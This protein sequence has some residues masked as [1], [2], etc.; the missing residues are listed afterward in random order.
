MTPFPDD[1]LALP[2]IPVRILAD[3]AD[4][5]RSALIRGYRT[6][7]IGA[8]EGAAWLD[9]TIADGAVASV[10]ERTTLPA[11]VIPPENAA[12]AHVLLFENLFRDPDRPGDDRGDMACGTF[13]LA[14]ALAQAG[15]R[16]TLIRGALDEATGLDDTGRLDAVLATDPPDLVGITVL[17]ACLPGVAALVRH[18]SQKT[19]AVLAVGGPMVTWTPL[20][21]LAHLPGAHLA[22]RG[23]GEEVLP[24][25]AGLLRG[26]LDTLSDEAILRQD[27]VIL[28]RDGRIVAGKL[29]RPA[30]V[31]VDWT[32]M[33]FEL[34]QDRHLQTG[35]SLETGR[36][37]AHG[38]L[39]CT[40]PGR[41]EHRGRRGAVVADH[42]ERYERRLETLY[43][44]DVPRIARRLQ[45]CDD[46]FTSDPERAADVLAAVAASGLKLSAFQASV[47]DLIDRRSGEVRGELL[48]AI[49]PEMFQ[50]VAAVAPTGPASGRL[51]PHT[52]AFVHLGIESFAGGDL[53]RLGKGY[54]PAD[55]FDVVAALDGRGIVHDVY[56]ILGNRGTT[57]DD[58]V[59]SLT[60][61][62][63]LKIQHPHT[64]FLR[65]PVVPFVVPTYPS[66]LYRAWSRGR[67]RGEDLGEVEVEQTLRLEGIPE[68]DY[69]LVGRE[70]PAD[71][72]AAA[73]CEAW[74]AW[75]E[76]D[77]RYE[78]PLVN[79]RKWLMQRL[80]GVRD[81]D[82]AVR[83]RRAARK[84]S[85]AR[86]RI[87]LGGVARARRNQLRREVSERYWSEAADLGLP[88]EVIPRVRNA[89]EVGDPRLVVI[90][91][92]DCSLRCAYCPADK[93]PGLEMS[94]ET[95]RRSVELLLS[96]DAPRA[97]L[98]FFGGEALL[99]R[100][101]VL[102]TLD[103]GLELATELGKEIG[104]ILSTNGLSLDPDL[105]S[106]LAHLPVKVEISLDGGPRVHNLH[107]RAADPAIDSY[108]LVTRHLDDLFDSGI[109]H[110]VIMVVTPETVADLCD[111]FAHVAALGFRRIQVNHGLAV[112]WSKEHK[113]AL[114][115]QLRAIE[116]RFFTGAL[117]DAGVEWIDL[118]SFRDP[119]LLNGETT[120]DHDGTVY[121]GNGFLIRTADPA[122]FRA[123]HLDDLEAFDA[124]TFAR[125]ENAYL[126]RHTYPADVARNNIEVGRIYGS[127]VQYMR[128][129]FPQLTQPR[130][131]RCPQP[132][133]DEP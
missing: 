64:F 74:Q 8:D 119:M 66:A 111:S 96:T 83:I 105:L 128:R 49:R 125:P 55:A 1:R 52:G 38:C 18:L 43:G 40:T 69:P 117:E 45:I 2:S 42:L 89:L 44:P 120:V 82:R 102:E 65:L 94:R 31:D 33:R 92:R 46:D 123:G 130:P 29:D 90:P 107:R 127:F 108:A 12:P 26:G 84:L 109:D 25:L 30:R 51:P 39:F 110:E 70:V 63:R 37:C 54:A 19:D 35:L 72:D 56:L 58:L 11:H 87:V 3:D 13:Q 113:Q 67:E 91:T 85:S 48:D 114:A 15:H 7:G 126:V 103:F 73:A 47:G 115:E 93:A 76:P 78:Q 27:G 71:E 95:M 122:R 116:Q 112:L 97:I 20:H 98:Q 59:E 81:G 5:L 21:A 77:A 34:L 118:R 4:T 99:R 24:R 28:I 57:L 60:A 101:A 100:Q 133:R 6:A 79:L 88:D 61:L 106:H 16:I 68:M 32:P 86:E 10:R 36:G 129:R 131:T 22:V 23:D 17:E 50:D 132:G 124:Y 121:H 80:P 53:R 41:R 75:I 104:F 62:C 9:V 14:S